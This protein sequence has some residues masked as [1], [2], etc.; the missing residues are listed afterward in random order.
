MGL[1]SWFTADTGRCICI[2][3]SFTVYMHAVFPDGSR[4]MFEEELY[5]GSGEFGGKNYIDLLSEMNPQWG[6]D[7]TVHGKHLRGAHLS[8]D[9][10]RY[11]QLTETAEFPPLESFFKQCEICPAQGFFYN[12]QDKDQDQEGFEDEDE[13]DNMYDNK[14][15]D[16]RFEDNRKKDENGSKTSKRELDEMEERQVGAT[17]RIKSILGTEEQM[18]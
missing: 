8:K 4:P 2:V 11:P 6:D 9:A 7:A 18:T 1:F 10:T 3:R 16:I 14:H 15:D 17:K 5:N 12:L 13:Q